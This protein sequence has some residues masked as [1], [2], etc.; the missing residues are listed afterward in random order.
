MARLGEKLAER[1]LSLL[2]LPG[3]LYLATIRAAL[4]LGQTRPFDLPRLAHQVTAW[5][6]NPAVR[7]VGGQIVLLCA[8]L[9]AAAVAG[10]AARTLA[11]AIERVVLAADWSSWPGPLRR[12]ASARVTAR[13]TRWDAARLVV[14]QRREE[15]GR[16]RALRRPHDPQ[17][18]HEARRSL[19]RIS[20]ERPSRPTWTGDRIDAATVRL[21]RDHHLETALLWPHLW[22]TLPDTERSEISTARQEMTAAYVL[23]AWAVLYAPL[24]AIWW[25]AALVSLLLAMTARQRSRTAAEAYA[26]LIEATVRL[27]TGDLARAL[28]IDHS[29]ILTTQV[30]DALS[31]LLE[32][33]LP[34]LDEHAS[35]AGMQ[36]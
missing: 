11:A 14:H 26:Q 1:W 18:L 35:T 10:I 8:V 25:P 30:G 20:P 7:T 36:V 29:G 5:A 24:T 17:E 9:A 2:V 12:L 3:A 23:A 28:G 22:L 6:A 34:E 27:H 13:R 31:D 15:A 4:T 21:R 33:R 32:S 16:A 19:D